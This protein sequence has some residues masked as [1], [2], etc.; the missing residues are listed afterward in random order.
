MNTPRWWEWAGAFACFVF[1]AFISS[2]F[3][4][5]WNYQHPKQKVSL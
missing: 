2:A 1:F 3:R 5:R 4:A